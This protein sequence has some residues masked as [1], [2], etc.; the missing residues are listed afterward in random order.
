MTLSKWMPWFVVPLIFF[1]IAGESSSWAWFPRFLSDNLQILVDN[2]A[3]V[4][5]KGFIT[6]PSGQ[7]W[8]PTVGQVIILIGV[9]ILAVELFKSAQDTRGSVVDHMLSILVFIFYF[10]FFLSKPWAR[11]DVFVLMGAMSFLD[12][13]TGFTI[14]IAIAR[15]DMVISH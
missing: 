1:Y 14:T 15:R 7:S 8:N 9:L 10:A 4:L 12:V 5:P 11:N 6:L 2:N 13:V 3:L